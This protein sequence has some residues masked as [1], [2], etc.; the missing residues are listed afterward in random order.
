MT[1]FVLRK[2][3]VSQM[4]RVSHVGDRFY[5]DSA[6]LAST[7]SNTNTTTRM[8]DVETEGRN[9]AG[10]RQVRFAHVVQSELQLRWLAL[11]ELG[12]PC[13][14]GGVRC[15]VVAL[16][17]KE[18]EAIGSRS[19]LLAK[20]ARIIGRLLFQNGTRFSDKYLDRRQLECPGSVSV[21]LGYSSCDQ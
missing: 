6:I 1:F 9:G 4:V 16:V 21:A 8:R 14:Q 18:S 19:F 10:H 2:E 7:N 12:E 17:F 20:Y 11:Q 3:I 15:N 13:S 5:V